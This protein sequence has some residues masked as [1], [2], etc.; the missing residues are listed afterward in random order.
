M[1]RKPKKFSMIE[2]ILTVICIVFVAEAAAPVASMGNS[3]FFW[4]IILIILYLVPYGLM[5]AELG[6]TYPGQGGLYDWVK[7]AYGSKM[8]TREAWYYWVNYPIW[9]ASLAV[10]AP[11]I[12]RLAFG[13]NI[14]KLGALI[15][16][17]VF[18]WLVVIMSMFRVSDSAWVLK[19]SAI[20]K[21]FLAVTVGVLGISFALKHGIA[22]EMTFQSF[23]PKFDLKSLSFLGV[24]IFNFHG[25]E[26]IAT[27]SHTM[28]HPKRQIPLSIIIGGLVIAMIYL[29]TAFGIG[30]AIP[31]DQI[32]TSTGL[33]DSIEILTGGGRSIFLSV[34]SMLFMVTLFG[35]M[36]AWA[37]GANSVAA[38]AAENGD[39]PKIFGT[40]SKKTGMPR[41]AGVMN[42][43]VASAIVIIAIFIPNEDL[44]WSFF[45]LNLVMI[46]I[47]YALVFPTFVKLRKIDA[48]VER[49]FKVSGKKGFIIAFAASPF[50]ITIAAIILLVI[51]T[52]LSRTNVIESLPISI[53]AVGFVI[54]GEIIVGICAHRTKNK[55][56]F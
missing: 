38:H 49:P 13:W 8:G 9:K 34:V 51:P 22:N 2:L 12:L 44:F 21:L 25:F 6:T 3:Q 53:G 14:S 28:E 31:S 20:I 10:M 17:L 47:A 15:I 23:L 36:M 45:A 32:S 42:G 40:R 27:M 4:W 50:I 33:I 39:M 1:E 55:C 11:M 19:G 37:L 48:N 18:I 46:L 43:L 41:G 35:N 7:R 56:N 52:S 26:I 29:F 16:E 54:M 30:V 24:I 5:A